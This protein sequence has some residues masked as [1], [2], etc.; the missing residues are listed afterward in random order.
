MWMCGHMKELNRFL[1]LNVKAFIK[2]EN[3]EIVAYNGN[4][5]QKDFGIGME[6]SESGRQN[7][8][9]MLKSRSPENMA[10]LGTMA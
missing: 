8:S 4:I 5:T 6:S 3:P 10:M 2:Q 9:K 1:C 7:P